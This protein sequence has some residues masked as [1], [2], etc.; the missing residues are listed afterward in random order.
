[1]LYNPVS[2]ATDVTYRVYRNALIYPIVLLVVS[3]FIGAYLESD[4]L[5]NRIVWLLCVGFS[6]SFFY[7]LREDSIW[8]LPLA[9]TT[10]ILILVEDLIEK[11]VSLRGILTLAIPI[12]VFAL[13]SITYNYTNYRYYGLWTVNDRTGGNFG[14][15]VGLMPRVEEGKVNDDNV[16]VSRESLE[17]IINNSPTLNG[18]SDSIITSYNNWVGNE[19]GELN[20][21]YYVWALRDAF[22]AQGY[23]DDAKNVDDICLKAYNELESSF[24]NGKLHEADMIYISSQANGI[25]KEKLPH[26]LYETLKN[27]WKDNYYFYASSYP[28]DNAPG[29][30]DQFRTFET[31]T[32]NLSVNPTSTDFRF[33]GWII[34]KE[35]S[36]IDLN[37]MNSE[38]EIISNIC[39]FQKSDDVKSQYPDYYNSGVSRFDI[40][41]DESLYEDD[42]VLDVV[43]DGKGYVISPSENYEN[44]SFIFHVDRYG[45]S[46]SSDSESS[47]ND[48]IFNLSNR[49]INIYRNTARYI[50]FLALICFTF[51]LL[52]SVIKRKKEYIKYIIISFGIL[53]SGYLLVF[54][55][56]VFSSWIGDSAIWFYSVGVVPMFH[57]FLII[58]YAIIIR[59]VVDRIKGTSKEEKDGTDSSANTVLQ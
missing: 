24:S 14:K 15:L 52:V 41:I 16:W 13:L 9:I 2:M 22:E 12:V 23:Y 57:I 49:I 29:S 1:M 31:V 46:Y 19:E 26:F 55:I 45:L 51:V 43:I 17:Y 5:K 42:L 30:Y 37:I 40:D 6:F 27:C 18:M 47:D 53:L 35:E 10:L 25:K 32:G 38:G 56:T 33:V 44:D 11:R 58:N 28:V 21:D 8:L 4:K 36:D 7:Y 39:S 48:Y 34:T 50:N 54:G 3:L 20:G 59:M